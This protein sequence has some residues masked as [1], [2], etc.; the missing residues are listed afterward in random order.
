MSKELLEA[1]T[2]EGFIQYGAV[3]PS[4]RV[5]DIMGIAPPDDDEIH[6]MSFRDIGKI[7][8]KMALEEL[9]AIDY[10]R[11]V[12]LGRGM[13][14][15]NEKGDYRILLPSE[16]KKQVELYRASADRKLSRALK[17]SRNS[18]GDGKNLGW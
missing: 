15:A 12:L 11:N 4:Q 7:V 2:K 6:E 17:L 8:N 10:V 18:K 3:I 5:R 13:Y 14:I 1:L 16:N 9:T